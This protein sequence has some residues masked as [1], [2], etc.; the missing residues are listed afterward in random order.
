LDTANGQGEIMAALGRR[1]IGAVLAAGVLGGV[2]VGPAG[3]AR[4][5]G[6][7]GGG[8]TY[9]TTGNM[10]VTVS[11]GQFPAAGLNPPYDVGAVGVPT[12]SDLTVIRGRADATSPVVGQFPL[13]FMTLQSAPAPS[14]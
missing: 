12:T 14:R 4:A 3:T 7:V 9:P 6:V 10:P 2:L 11:V 1:V 8:G 13:A 5:Q